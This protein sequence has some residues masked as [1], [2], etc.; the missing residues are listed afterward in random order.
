MD[1]SVKNVRE[2]ILIPF[3]KRNLPHYYNKITYI[4]F[5]CINIGLMMMMMYSS[6][7]VAL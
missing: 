1:F 4:Q 2:K 7:H 5:P 3:S 6:K